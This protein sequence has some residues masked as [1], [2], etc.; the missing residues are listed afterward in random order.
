MDSD[1]P[2]LSINCC[3][4]HSM[5]EMLLIQDL[6]C[7]FVLP[8]QHYLHNLH[9]F[10]RFS[11]WL[12]M[13]TYLCSLW[14]WSQ[15]WAAML[16]LGLPQHESKLGAIPFFSKLKIYLP[17][18]LLCCSR[19]WGMLNV[20]YISPFTREENFGR[21]DFCLMSSSWS[22][23]EWQRDF[24]RKCSSRHAFFNCSETLKMFLFFHNYFQANV[25]I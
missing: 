9:F 6:G 7:R 3:K 25:D 21:L 10:H 5:Q 22:S 16:R 20:L 14:G 2:V 19:R 15:R 18:I 12:Q 1:S 4:S 11:L 13:A 23:E 24:W 17:R 8:S